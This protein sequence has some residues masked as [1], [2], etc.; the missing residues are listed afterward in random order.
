[1]LRRYR[2]GG[3][4]F[5]GIILWSVELRYVCK[6]V[7]LQRVSFGF[8]RCEATVCHSYLLVER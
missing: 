5:E 8:L 4:V 1:M 7:F 3:Y 2:Y 6:R